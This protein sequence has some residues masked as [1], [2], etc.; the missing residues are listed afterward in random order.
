MDLIST[1]ISGVG[2]AVLV[3]LSVLE[4][5]LLLYVELVLVGIAMVLVVLNLAVVLVSEPESLLYL[6]L[7]LFLYLP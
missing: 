1:H 2:L 3:L 4:P 5:K 7:V 6:E